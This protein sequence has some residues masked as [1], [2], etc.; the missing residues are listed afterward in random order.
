MIQRILLTTDFSKCARHAYLTAT[1]IARRLNASLDLAHVLEFPLTSDP[2]IFDL[3]ERTFEGYRSSV[4]DRLRSEADHSTF[5]DAPPRTHLLEGYGPETLAS[6]VK[7][8][9]IDLLVQASH[10]YAGWKH[11]MLGSFAERTL[12]YAQVPV[13]TVKTPEDDEREPVPFNPR[14]ILLPSDLSPCSKEA[15]HLT[16][17]LAEEYDAFVHVVHAWLDHSNLAALYGMSPETPPVDLSPYTDRLE[18]QLRTDLKE[19]T[20]RQFSGIDH[21]AELVLGDAVSV[22]LERAQSA[23]DNLIC[24]ATHGWRGVKHLF[25]G[26]IAEKVVRGADCPV[27]TFRARSE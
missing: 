9:S 6:F 8:N 15:A 16:R 24:M 22:I 18:N 7:D 25:M 19:F 12:R 17:F 14:R 23:G 10:G 20:D 4:S 27:L 26:S 21:E 2:A 11:F 13:L 1:S 5:E 3:K